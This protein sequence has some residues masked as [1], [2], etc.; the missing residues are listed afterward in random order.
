MHR[1][2]HPN[3]VKNRNLSLYLFFACPLIPYKKGIHALKKSYNQT[4]QITD[5]QVHNSGRTQYKDLSKAG[6]NLFSCSCETIS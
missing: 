1:L 6:Q 5:C 3:S 2:F 4:D